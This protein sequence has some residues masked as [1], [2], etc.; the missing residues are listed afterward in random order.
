MF[1]EKDITS[2]VNLSDRTFSIQPQIAFPTNS[3]VNIS[4]NSLYNPSKSGGTGNFRLFTYDNQSNLI[5]ESDCF[6]TIGF[7]DLAEQLQDLQV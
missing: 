6:G 4:I 3:Q 1:L 2:N 7:T 5:D